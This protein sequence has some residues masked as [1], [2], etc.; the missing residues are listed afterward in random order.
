MT[1]SEEI[2]EITY[3]QHEGTLFFPL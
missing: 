1:K 3:E 2:T